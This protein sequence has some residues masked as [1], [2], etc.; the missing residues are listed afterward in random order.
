[1]R[2]G[3]RRLSQ[4]VPTGSIKTTWGEGKPGVGVVDEVDV[5]AVVP[6]DTE[7][8]DAVQR[9]PRSRKTRCGARLLRSNTKVEWAPLSNVCS[10]I[11]SEED[12]SRALARLVEQREGAGGRGVGK[13]ADWRCRCCA[14]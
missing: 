8:C 1:M 7:L 4:P 5:G 9:R 10:D 6:G 2:S 12:R 13:L 3:S 11:G 14:R